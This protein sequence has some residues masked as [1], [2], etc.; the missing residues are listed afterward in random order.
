VVS[1]L[2]L[3]KVWL[4]LIQIVMSLNLR[5]MLLLIR[6]DLDLIQILVQVTMQVMVLFLLQKGV[7][8]LFQDDVV[9]YIVGLVVSSGFT[10]DDSNIGIVYNLNSDTSESEGSVVSELDGNVSDSAE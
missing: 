7:S 8:L 10:C 3:Q 5:K 2:L 1:S 6:A 9:S 4:S